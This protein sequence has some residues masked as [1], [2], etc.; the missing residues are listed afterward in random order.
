M[1]KDSVL[2]YVKLYQHILEQYHIT[3]SE[4]DFKNIYKLV[5]LVFQLDD[6]YDL[7]GKSFKN[8]E[9][10]KIKK[11]MINLMPNNHP[12]GL[13]AIET[14]FQAMENEISLN[15]SESLTKYLTVAS[16]SIG[17]GIL[18]GYLASRLALESKVW[19]SKII[20]EFNDEIDTIIRLANDYLDLNTHQKRKLAEIPQI[21]A[22][23]FFN[24]KSQY[25]RYLFSRYVIHKFRYLV[26]L[27]RFK[28][29]KL[30][31]NWKEHWQ[32]IICSESILDWAFKV[33]V[34]DRN[35]CQE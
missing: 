32:A 17:S 3:L 22:L 31:S 19:F 18:T 2:A 10:A 8:H 5:E 4:E 1:N 7:V 13:S 33:Y 15:L 28:Y 24:N 21:K 6:L 29:L 30:S 35:S 20:I 9:L 25:K 27:I 11:T 26:Y 23:N 14:L 16:K 34:I 12:I